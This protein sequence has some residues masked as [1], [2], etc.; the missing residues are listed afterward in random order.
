MGPDVCP[1]VAAQ[2]C[3]IGYSTRGLLGHGSSLGKASSTDTAI[4]AGWNL[5]GFG[6]PDPDNCREYRHGSDL[7]P[8]LA[9]RGTWTTDGSQAANS[10]I[11][12]DGVEL[13]EQDDI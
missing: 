11:Q 5:L 13:E 4:A 6:L 3:G 1:P 7:Q 8:R 9:A 2:G 12:H 10:P